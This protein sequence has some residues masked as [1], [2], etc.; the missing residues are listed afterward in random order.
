MPGVDF[1]AVRAAVPIARV[2]ELVG[3]EIRE[4]SGDQVRGGCPVHGSSSPKSRTFSANLCQKHLPVL[5]VPFERKPV[6]SLGRH[7]QYAFVRGSDHALRKT[8]YRGTH[9]PASTGAN[10]MIPKPRQG[11]RGE[12]LVA[13]LSTRA[14]FTHRFL[15]RPT[16][17]MPVT[18]HIMAAYLVS[19]FSLKSNWRSKNGIA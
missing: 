17:N 9:D 14:I 15:G 8:E 12:E 1:R 13:G 19:L 6:G 3:F 18:P 5:Q 2:L 7:H 16:C 10:E 11:S 4:R